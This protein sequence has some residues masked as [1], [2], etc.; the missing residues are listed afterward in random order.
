MARTP[1]GRIDFLDYMRVF[2]FASVLIGHL[3]YQDLLVASVDP[4]LHV[5]F[6]QLARALYDICYAGASGVIVFFLVS[7]YIITHV[8][9]AETATDFIIRRI[10]RI[11]PLFIVA[12]FLEIAA[13][14]YVGVPFPALTE[15]LPKLLLLGDF[16]GTPYSLGGVEW[17][18]RVEIL[19]YI[20]MVALKST[21]IL[22]LTRSLPFIFV[23]LSGL[24][25]VLAP[26]PG[27]AGWTN[28]Y[29]NM[30][31]PFLL[32]GV[33]FYLSEHGLAGKVTCM[34]AGTAILGISLL[35][36][37]TLKPMLADSNFEILALA[38]FGGAWLFRHQ[39]KGNWITA[40]LSELTYSVYLIHLWLW[41]YLEYAVN[42]FGVSFLPNRLQRLV[43][44]FIVCLV[45]AKTVEKYGVKL[46][47][48]VSKKA[49]SF[50]LTKPMNNAP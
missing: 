7:G 29:F 23:A 31:F 4:S 46:G 36:I 5:A 37:P 22:S 3:F 48:A 21:G 30:F 11:Y 32:I 15:V 9:R 45:L 16:F 33:L 24:L 47:R 6:R 50:N 34:L 19:F 43:F 38:L 25:A 27:W 41:P 35:Q 39:I 13:A 40:N 42:K 26:F 20:F 10:F 8:I 1:T 12:V 18:L 28:G 17:T 14:R 49:I 44:L 2:A